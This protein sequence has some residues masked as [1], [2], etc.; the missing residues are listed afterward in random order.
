MHTYSI[1]KT[2]TDLRAKVAVIIFGLSMVI[3][4]LLK[5]FCTDKLNEFA[6]VLRT[7]DLKNVVGLVEWFE[8]NPNVLGIPFCYGVLTLIYRK[9]L[10]QI[11]PFRALHGIPKLKGKWKGSLTSSYNGKSIP[12]KMEVKQNWNKISF[13]CFFQETNSISNSNV[14]AILVDSNKGIEICF[15]FTNDSYDVENKLQSYDGYNILNLVDKN[16]IKAR[17]FNNRDNPNPECKG[18]NKGSFELERVKK[19]KKSKQK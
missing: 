11:W 17:Y 16:H 15:G 18:G 5:E 10:W 7:S 3:S 8:V 19:T 6:N 4:L 1:D 12:M 9:I 2:D 14:A 13:K